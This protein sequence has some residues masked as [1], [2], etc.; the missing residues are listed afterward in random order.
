M[1]LAAHQPQFCPWLGYFD[2]ARQADV[3]V[4]LDDVQFKKNEW[5]NRNKIK[6]PKGPAWLTV[7]VIHEFGQAIREVKI[8]NTAD[9]Q[10]KSLATVSQSYGRAESFSQAASFLDTLFGRRWDRLVDINLF[11]IEWISRRLGVGTPMKLSSELQV[12]GQAT[13]RL[14]NLCRALGAETYL[15][16]AGGH[17]YMDLGLFE[18]A[19]IQVRFQEYVHPVYKQLHGEF[20]S[21]LSA[22]DLILLEGD[23][24]APIA[25]R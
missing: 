16:G 13:E 22:I 23:R 3:F 2:K 10:R 17:D 12:Q 9:W 20:V 18:R 25:F 14:V 1:I 11:T 6:T 21:H 4:L 24:G 19:G 15:A 7:P 5:Q 8:N